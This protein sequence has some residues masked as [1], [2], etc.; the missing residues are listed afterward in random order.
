MPVPDFNASGLLPPGV[1][2]CTLEEAK[3]RFGSFHGSDRR[4]TLFDSLR[5]LMADMQ[6]A[7]LFVAIVLDGS[8]VTAVAAPNDIDLILVLRRTHDWNRDPAVREYNVLSRRRLRRRFKFD[9]FLAVDG[10]A[11]YDEMVAFFGGV[12]ERPDVRKGILRIEL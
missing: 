7:D 3:E 4:P 11:G 9:A 8:F 1:H 5:A 10:D 6:R 12:R 2:V